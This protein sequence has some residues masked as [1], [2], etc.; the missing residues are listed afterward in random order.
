MSAITKERIEQLANGNNICKVTREERIELA[1]IA[2]AS[3]EAEPV[4]LRDERSGS[5]GISKKPGFNDLPHGAP[6][7]TAHPAPVSVPDEVTAE[8]CPAFVKYDV[9]DADEAWARGFNACRAAMLQG[10]DGTLTNEG[11]IPVTQFKSV[12]DL[13]GLTSPTGGE[14]SFT[15]D[16]V[17]ARDFIDGGW[18]CQE[19]VELERFQEAVIG[20]SPA[21]PDGWALVPI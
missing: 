15:F 5:G 19:Y 7:Y 1:R 16:A 18:L 17:E 3:L 4:A 9:T 14:T 2:L 20:N 13:Y 11:T 8:D 6:L 10:A 12:A 21:I